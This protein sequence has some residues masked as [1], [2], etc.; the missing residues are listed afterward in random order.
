MRSTN[1]FER[2]VPSMRSINDFEYEIPYHN[3]F[4]VEVPSHITPYMVG[5]KHTLDGVKGW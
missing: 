1:D 3:N 4:E 5:Y 2:E